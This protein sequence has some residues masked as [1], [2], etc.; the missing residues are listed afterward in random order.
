M[1]TS[2]CTR[3]GRDILYFPAEGQCKIHRCRPGTFFRRIFLAHVFGISQG[4][5]IVTKL[6]RIFCFPCFQSCKGAP[7]NATP[8]PPASRIRSRASVHS[9]S[10]SWRRLGARYTFPGPQR[11]LPW[12]E[13]GAFLRS[14][15]RIFRHAASPRTPRRVNFTICL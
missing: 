14:R 1:E 8:R 10:N 3:N 4:Y 9:M 5:Q 13:G 7:D 2:T 11:A 12:E 15:L 6:K